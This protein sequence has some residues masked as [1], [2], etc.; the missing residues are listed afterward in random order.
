MAF[1]KKYRIVRRPAALNCAYQP[2][3]DQK[4]KLLQKYR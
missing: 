1:V 3:T 4:A 2:R